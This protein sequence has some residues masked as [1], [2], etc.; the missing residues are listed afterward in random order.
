MDG[1]KMIMDNGEV[2]ISL[3]VSV[4]LAIYQIYDVAYPSQLKK[5]FSFLEAFVLKLETP[6]TRVAIAVQRVANVL[7]FTTTS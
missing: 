3:A 4:V 6:T 2:D 1:H 7:H 5:T